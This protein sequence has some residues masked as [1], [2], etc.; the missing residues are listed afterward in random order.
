[1]TNLTKTRPEV[2]I[3]V[4]DD[5]PDNLRLLAKMLESKN[6]RIR[7]A[8]SGRMALQAAIHSPPDL[9]LLDI[10]MP[11]MNGYEVCQQL[12]QFQ[13]TAE[14]PVIFVSALDQIDDKLRAFEVGGQDY[15]TKPFQELEVIARLEHQLLIQKQRKQLQQEIHSRQQAEEEVRRLNAELERQ[16]EGRTLELQQSLGFE[17]ALKN[18]SDKVRDSLDQHQIL[19]SAMATLA[20]ALDAPYCRTSLNLSEQ[21]PSTVQY[22]WSQP[23][24]DINPGL[25]MQKM[26]I[27]ELYVQLQQRICFA[28]CPLDYD[29]AQD[30]SAIIAC[31]IFDEQV[32]Q[33]GIVGDLWL[34]RNTYSSFGEMEVHLVQQVAN[35]CAIA[36]RQAR[37][38]EGTQAQVKELERLNQL[39][40]DFLSTISHELRTPI[41]NMKLVIELLDILIDKQSNLV[42]EF[43]NPPTYSNKIVEY[44][45][46]LHEECDRELALVE[47]LLN[48]QHI[49]AGTYS[50]EPEAIY[51][52]DFLPHLIEPFEARAQHQHQRFLIQISSSF[53]PFNLDVVSFRRVITELLSN[54]FKYTPAGE[55]ISVDADL[56]SEY[57]SPDADPKLILRVTNTGVEIPPEEISRIFDKFYRIPNNDPWKHGGTGLGL[58]L[59][60][61]LVE[62]MKGTIRVESSQG[63]T[64]FTVEI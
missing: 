17:I 7:K 53:P 25:I 64:C 61:K 21:Q 22:Q 6:Y 40:N 34:F 36:L 35:Q 20:I 29:T 1:M 42:E 12:R 30:Y 39:K 51:I 11:E 55:T 49:E 14:I 18:I 9:I 45:R 50:A 15:I 28:F 24:I 60:K 44:L 8:L 59:A 58:A 33:T 16:V 52:Q 62:Q 63:K 57:R 27:P 3:L 43:I 32:D 46:V 2:Q 48:L 26:Q 31:P 41:A 5:T 4:V 19:Q 54:A 47:D 38:F 37:L 10:N 13:S 56:S 23:N